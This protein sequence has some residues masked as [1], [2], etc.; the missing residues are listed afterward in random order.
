[1]PLL[2]FPTAGAAESPI[3]TDGP[4][5]VESSEVVPRGRSQVEV[6][7]TSTRARRSPADTP[8]TSTPTLLK[9]GFAENLELRVA[10]SG[11]LRQDGRSGSGDTAIGLK[12]HAQDRGGVGG[13]PAVSWILH[14]DLPSGSRAVRGEGLRPSLRSVITWE[15]PGDYALGLMPG[16]RRDSAD[17]GHRFTSGIFGAVLNKKL[18]ES[19]RAFVELAVPQW[20][21]SRDG[22]VLAT[23]D[24][25]AARL[26]GNDAQ[27]GVRAG[28]AANRN[29]PGSYVLLELARRF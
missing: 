7:L 5:F 23:W 12:W 29:T 22:G 1:M 13:A 4:D 20:A 6:D 3:D 19:W 21:R 11:Y 26:F 24:A 18:S 15:L 14:A 17:G 25:G 16:L 28:V 8:T 9:Y 27:I 10:P 2:I